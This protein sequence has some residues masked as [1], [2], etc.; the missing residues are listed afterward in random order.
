MRVIPKIGPFKS[1]AFR[2]PTPEVE[3]MFMASFNATVDAYRGLL[4]NVGRGRL[5]LPNDN[6]DTG[7]PVA[8]GNYLGADEAYDHLL[9]KLEDR[10]F[11]GISP[12]LRGNLLDYYKDRKAPADPSSKKAAE[13]TKLMAEV[14][15][16]RATAATSS[17]EAAR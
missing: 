1:L 12:E 4:D 9:G 7:L 10:K 8:A 15:A 3:K 5:A 11:T 6:F 14:E 17:T 13:W 16:L 2:A